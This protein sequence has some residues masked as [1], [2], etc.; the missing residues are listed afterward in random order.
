MT[1]RGMVSR[2]L[3]ASLHGDMVATE[4]P[5]KE[6][7]KACKVATPGGRRA[8]EPWQSPV[9]SHGGTIATLRPRRHQSSA[10][11]WGTVAP[12]VAA[13]GGFAWDARARN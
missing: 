10:G 7:C 8:P 2:V 5:R 6:G 9:G 4:R 3:A 11:A 1:R 12:G 13:L